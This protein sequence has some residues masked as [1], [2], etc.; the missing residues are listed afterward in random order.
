LFY[1][2]YDYPSG[3]VGTLFALVFM[4]V[5]WAATLLLRHYVHD[6]FHTERRANDMVGFMLSSYS[7]LYGIL[8]GLIAV[9]AYQ[10]YGTVSDVVEKEASSLAALYRDLHGYPQPARG[11]LQGLLRDYTHY[12]VEGSWPLQEQGVVP[13][14]GTHRISQFVDE[15]VSFEPQ[16]KRDEIIHAETL[17]QLNNYLNLR[18]ERLSSVTEGIPEVLWWV[19]GIGALISIVLL[20]M[21]DMEIHVHLILGAA[22]SM[23]LGLI[24]FLIAAMDNPYRGEVSVSAEPFKSVLKTLMDP[25]DTVNS[26]MALL[27]SKT[28][29]LGPPR[30]EGT[31]EVAG[32]EVP[33]LYFGQ[34]RMNSTFDVVDQ[35]AAEKG[36]T[37]TLFV[38]K[39]D[40]FVRVSTNVRRDDGSRAIG[41]V[42]DPQGPAIQMI[43]RGEAYYGE[44]TILGK[45]YVTGYEPMKDASGEII[46]IYYTGYRKS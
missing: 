8:V 26:A 40:E 5:T 10:N 16:Q 14:E 18:Q 31:E 23:F 24:I 13:T 37:A 3:L 44:A 20:A 12:V 45:P 22:M 36:G 39:G 29:K 21:L 1:W 38:R 27:I 19:V 6:W 25:D 35:V 43:R 30:L 17:R 9:A 34:T 2:I 7:V 11:H 4:L 46:G 28:S 33:T 15:L 32:R 42:L 41:T